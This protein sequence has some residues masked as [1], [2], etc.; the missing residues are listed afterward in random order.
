MK[1]IKRHQFGGIMQALKTLFSSPEPLYTAPIN[2]PSKGHWTKMPPLEPDVPVDNTTY[3]GGQLP[4]I[5]VTAPDL[6]KSQPFPY[7]E[8]VVEQGKKAYPDDGHLMGQ[9]FKNKANPKRGQLY[10]G[11]GKTLPTA[12]KATDRYKGG[13]IID[14][15]SQYFQTS[16]KYKDGTSTGVVENVNYWERTPSII[17]QQILDK[18]TIYRETPGQERFALRGFPITR[19]ASYSGNNKEEYNVLKRRFNEAKS[20]AKHQGGGLV[21]R[22]DNTRVASG[23]PQ[24]IN[25]KIP[26]GAGKGPAADSPM[27]LFNDPYI[28]AIMMAMGPMAGRSLKSLGTPAKTVNGVNY[29]RNSNGQLVTAQ[30][31]AKS[32]VNIGPKLAKKVDYKKAP[33]SS[34]ERKGIYDQVRKDSYDNMVEDGYF[35]ANGRWV[36]NNGINWD[37]TRPIF[38]PKYAEGIDNAFLMEGIK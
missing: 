36:N 30:E 11:G 37:F 29:Y 12:P 1:L 9:I 38:K 25:N 5:T 16:M 21:E 28:G 8:I 2:R 34:V 32:M 7:G 18:D 26:Y 13:F 19:Q 17:T 31:M 6:S 3:N 14:P 35:D 15:N 10:Q 33:Q 27:R 23:R 22:P 24:Q 4:G 20:V